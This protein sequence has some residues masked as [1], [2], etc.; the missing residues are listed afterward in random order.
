[1]RRLTEADGYSI[2]Y[3]TLHQNKMKIKPL[4][5]SETIIIK[6]GH[7]VLSCEIHDLFAEHLF[8]RT[9]TGDCFCFSTLEIDTD[10]T[11]KDFFFCFLWLSEQYTLSVFSPPAFAC[12]KSTLEQCV[13]SVQI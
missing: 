1:M 2:K 6:Y 12:P 11:D 3:G 4:L 8:Y 13:K 9:H 7:H 5:S 10:E